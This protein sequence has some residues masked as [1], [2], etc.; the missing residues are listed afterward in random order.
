MGHDPNMK[1]EE[2]D[3]T[4]RAAGFCE[5]G[6]ATGGLP[7][8]TLGR[9]AVLGLGAALMAT[10]LPRAVSAQSTLVPAGLQASLLAKVV[11]YDRNFAARAG[12]R[13]KLLLMT[14][15]D[16]PESTRFATEIKSALGSI[17]TVG[18]LPHDDELVAYTDGASL[19]TLC[20]TR[21]AAIVYFGPGFGKQMGEI[22]AALSSVDVLSLGGVPDYVSAGVV[23]G[24]NLVSGKA[25]LMVHLSQARSQHVN[26][27][28]EALK[29]MTVI[30]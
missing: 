19:A 3:S 29:L 11:S 30:E 12:D 25:K 22:R 14:R 7:S 8:A 17:E 16:D 9:R 1:S 10:L 23:L 6:S 27:Q 4:R 5:A 13:A 28:A 21:R 20:K 15:A 24:F 2:V 18:G 26:F